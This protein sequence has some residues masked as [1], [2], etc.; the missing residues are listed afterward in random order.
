MRIVIN[1]K[2][3]TTN[4]REHDVQLVL[5]TSCADR[6]SP[7]TYQALEIIFSLNYG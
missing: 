3:K 7:A 1:L 5:I 2:I 4:K 6:P